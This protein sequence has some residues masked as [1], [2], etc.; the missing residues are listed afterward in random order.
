MPAGLPFPAADWRR[1]L[2]VFCYLTGWRIASVLAFRKEDLAAAG[3]AFSVAE[4]NKGGRDARV[5]P[6]PVVLEHVKRLA[7]FSPTVFPWPHDRRTLD[8]EFDRIQ[9]AAGIKRACRGKHE[10]TDACFV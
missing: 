7:H 5:R 6:H 3:Q 8:V 10:P 1:G 9:R 4:D 2:L